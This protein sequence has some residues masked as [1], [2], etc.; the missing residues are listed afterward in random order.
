MAR[1]EYEIRNR[2]VPFAPAFILFALVAGFVF[3]CKHW[4]PPDPNW[5]PIPDCGGP[6]GRTLAAIDGASGRTLINAE[7][8]PCFNCEFAQRCYFNNDH[9]CCADLMCLECS[10][11]P[12]TFGRHRN[13]STDGGSK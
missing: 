5:K 11:P 9:Y 2:P 10:V 13:V 12:G 4:P 7:L 6:V 3:G 8:A 1:D